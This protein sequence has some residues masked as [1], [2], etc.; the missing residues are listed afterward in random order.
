MTDVKKF[1][2]VRSRQSDAQVFLTYRRVIVWRGNGE[3]L[4]VGKPDEVNKICRVISQK[5][6]CAY[7][8]GDLVRF[9]Q[10]LR[11]APIKP[12]QL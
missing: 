6:T 8:S 5:L 9:S 11:R 2:L 7:K 12:F 10:F 3:N 4:F 1:D